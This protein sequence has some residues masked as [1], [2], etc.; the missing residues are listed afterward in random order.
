[1]NP[2]I[3]TLVGAL[4]AGVIG[5]SITSCSKDFPTGPAQPAGGDA[6]SSVHTLSAPAN[7]DFANAVVVTRFP[8]THTVNTSEA[9]TAADDPVPSCAEG[10]QGPTVWY[11]FT[12]KNSKRIEANTF[13]SD[14]DTVIT[15]WEDLGGGDLGFVDCNDDAVGLESRVR[16][17]AVGGTTYLM[18]VGGCCGFD[19]GDTGNLVFNLLEGPPPVL[20]DFTIDGVSVNAKTGVVTLRTTVTCSETGGF[21]FVDVT[22][23]QRVGRR[24]IRGFGFAE[25]ECAGTTLVTME[26]EGENGLFVGGRATVE[27]FACSDEECL[28]AF[29]TVRL[30]GH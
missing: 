11:A 26:I 6:A 8:F 23:R 19:S 18:Q 15:V 29:A 25:I 13:G 1:M 12:P 14:Y 5:L 3:K 27:A 2:S 24:I 7:D 20:E 30:R 21:V 4:A 28:E 17:D 22:L 9:T 10:G 16:W